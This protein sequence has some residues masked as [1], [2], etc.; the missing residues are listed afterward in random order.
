MKDVREM[1]NELLEHLMTVELPLWRYVQVRDEL[2]RR[3]EK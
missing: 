3:K 1:S 2:K